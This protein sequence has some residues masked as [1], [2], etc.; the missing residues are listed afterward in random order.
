[1]KLYLSFGYVDEK[2]E[3][4]RLFH[5]EEPIDAAAF[6]TLLKGMRQIVGI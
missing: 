1:M 3:S 4:T 2:N 6:I 5:L